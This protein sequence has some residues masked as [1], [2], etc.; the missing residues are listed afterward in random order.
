LPSINDP[1][2]SLFVIAATRA[3]EALFA[4]KLQYDD[5]AARADN[6]LD[7]TKDIQAK[8]QVRI[9]G[10]NEASSVY[11]IALTIPLGQSTY[12][13]SVITPPI[14]TAGYRISFS[15]ST[16]SGEGFDLPL[17][18]TA[19]S[20]AFFNGSG[21]VGTDQY[22]V[23]L[24]LSR[25]FV[26]QGFGSWLAEGNADLHL[27]YETTPF[28]ENPFISADR[29]FISEIGKGA[30]VFEGEVAFFDVI[31]GVNSPFNIYDIQV[32]P[33]S[34]GVAFITTAPLAAIPEPGTSALLVLGL[35]VVAFC[36]RRRKDIAHV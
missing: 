30:A 35:G 7:S 12:T 33:E 36:V 6:A 17:R 11:R 25:N 31:G 13:V 4:T 1:A 14:V 5:L 9:N 24:K 21:V 34:A 32:N 20:L 16:F 2:T 19:G 28:S 22:T 23:T 18:F 3:T 29:I 27:S 8:I 26:V 15:G 10:I